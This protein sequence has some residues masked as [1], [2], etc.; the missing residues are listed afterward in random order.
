LKAVEVSWPQVHAFRLHRHHLDGRA[1]KSDLANVVGDIGG[2]QAQVMS[3]AELQVA[4]RVDCEVEDVRNAL[5]MDRSL[6]KTWLMRGTLHLAKSD[7]LP[8]YI[9]AMTALWKSQMRPS[10]LTHMQTTEAEFWQIVDRIGATL[11]G[12]PLTREELIAVVGQGKSERIRQLLGSG[13]GGML[14]PAAR[15]GLLCFGPNRGQSVTFVRPEKWLH[16][17][18]RVDKDNALALMARRYL[19]AYGPATKVD[20]ARWWGAWPGVGNAAWS[21][22]KDELMTVSVDGV[23]MQILE[24]DIDSLLTARVGDPVQLL[25]G[26]DTYLMG[27][28]KRDHLVDREFAS[29]VS[30][31]AGWISACVLLNGEAIGTWTH[32]L[33]KRKLQIIVTP[34][35]HIGASVTSELKKRARAIGEALSAEKTEVK[36]A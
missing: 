16:S 25:P 5:W 1:P 7:D 2:V 20:F 13:W 28:A 9:G 24:K 33:R 23:S 27:Y 29:R 30:R 11:D 14:K 35:R 21:A 8:L 17:W 34:F 4:V 12:E 15:S 31:T 26:F 3:A 18:H 22:L 10:W 6:V 19:S 32:A 36:F